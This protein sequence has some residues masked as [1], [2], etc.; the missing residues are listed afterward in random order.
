V[1]RDAGLTRHQQHTAVRIA[2]VPDPDFEEAVE[3]E[4]PPSEID[5]IRRALEPIVATPVGRPTN[6]PPTA[7]LL[8]SVPARKMPEAFR[9][10]PR[11]ETRDKIG[12]FAGVSGR[13]VE[14]IAKVTKAAEKASFPNPRLRVNADHRLGG[15]AR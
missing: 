6:P 8:G 2:R 7:P 3:A 1:A 13:T 15:R 9:D 5:A 10:R 12:S 11:G 14:K 4:H